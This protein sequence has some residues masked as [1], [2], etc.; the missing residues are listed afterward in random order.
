MYRIMKW[1]NWCEKIHI[2]LSKKHGDTKKLKT[3]IL[4]KIIFWKI[5]YDISPS[6][7]NNFYYCN[8]FVVLSVLSHIYNCVYNCNIK[9][10]I[11][12]A[13]LLFIKMQCKSFF[14]NYF[15]IIL[16]II[17]LVHIDRDYTKERKHVWTNF[18]YNYAYLYLIIWFFLPSCAVFLRSINKRN[19]VINN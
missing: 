13:I 16:L 18:T 4:K 5:M 8:I 1:L 3:V 10:C 19:V 7:L 14:P 15:A 11:I 17:F 12:I 2:V 9:Y 6:E